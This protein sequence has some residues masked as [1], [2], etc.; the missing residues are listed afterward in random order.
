MQVCHV[1]LFSWNLIYLLCRYLRTSSA[2]PTRRQVANAR[3]RAAQE[4]PESR[5]WGRVLLPFFTKKQWLLLSNFN[6]Q[7]HMSSGTGRRECDRPSSVWG[8]SYRK[9]VVRA[10]EQCYAESGFGSLR[11]ASSS[12][13]IIK[14][15]PACGHNAWCAYFPI[16]VLWKDC[17]WRIDTVVFHKIYFCR[18]VAWVI[19]KVMKYLPLASC[20]K[21]FFSI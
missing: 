21:Y 15:N 8:G 7:C 12:G 14:Q 18:Y 10:L 3:N 20:S 2:M 6:T 1:I 19:I 13:A 9:P 16:E 11:M 5:L 17:S 4:N